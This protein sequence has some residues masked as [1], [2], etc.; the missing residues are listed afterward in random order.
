MTHPVFHCPVGDQY[1]DGQCRELLNNASL[2]AMELGITIST[3]FDLGAHVGFASI[4]AAHYGCRVLSVEACP[5]TFRFLVE[6]IMMNDRSET[7]IPLCA[8]VVGNKT[9]DLAA[10]RGSISISAA[11]GLHCLEG[12]PIIGWA[13]QVELPFLLE[14]F[15]TPD[16]LKV[17][18]QGEE[19]KIFPLL[20]SLNSS[21]VACEFHAV[22]DPEFHTTFK[23]CDSDAEMDRLGYKKSK[24]HEIWVKK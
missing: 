3:M 21:I 24:Y 23:P 2:C 16:F 8:A 20:E 18:V 13:S 4:Y 19:H 1:L 10:L 14:R 5:F 7:V 11:V 22:S 12:L 6:N 17:D 15:G 9:G